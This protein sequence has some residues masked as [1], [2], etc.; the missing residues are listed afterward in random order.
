MT[1][2]VDVRDLL[3][4]PGAS[5]RQRLGPTVDGLGVE[6]A[7]V[8]NDV[9]VDADLL[10]EALVEGIMVSGSLRGTLALRCARCLRDSERPFE[11]DVRELFVADPD[12]EGDDYQLDPEG[13]LD[14]EQMIRDT[15]G[16]ELPFSPL[17]RPDCVGL[18]SVCG[19]D[20]NLGECPGHADVDPR[21]AA[22]DELAPLLDDR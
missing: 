5:R 22:L 11:V 7:A 17:C 2:A 16:V 1:V 15:I 10:L 3:G 18:C 9:P 14:L 4:R 8:R 20:L 6:L 13:W 21:W 12:E 19:A